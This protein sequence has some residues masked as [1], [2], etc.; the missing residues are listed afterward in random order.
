MRRAVLPLAAAAA[1]LLATAGAAS[2]ALTPVPATE[3]LRT[4]RISDLTGATSPSGEVTLLFADQNNGPTVRAVTRSATGAFGP[5][6]NLSFTPNGEGPKAAYLPDGSLFA[7][8]SHATSSAAGAFAS[9]PAGGFFEPPRALPTGE[10]FAE[11]AT[12]PAGQVVAVWKG[13]QTPGGLDFVTASQRFTNGAFISTSPVSTPVDDNFIQPQVALTP[14]GEVL[15]AWAAATSPTTSAIDARIGSLGTFAPTFPSP[16]QAIVPAATGSMR[17]DEVLAGPSGEGV[18]LMSVPAGATR[19][20]LLSRRAPGGAFGAPEPI[21]AQGGGARADYDGAGDLAIAWN[22][23]IATDTT[24]VRAAILPAGGTL[25]APVD[26]SAPG[27][28]TQILAVDHD[29][30]GNVVVAWRRGVDATSS[31]LEATRLRP[32][33]S[34]DPVITLL[35]PTSGAGSAAA[36]VTPAGDVVAAQ[37]EEV[38]AAV[39][40]LRVGGADSGAP[41]AFTSTT[42]PAAGVVGTPVAMSAAATDFSGIAAIDWDFGDGATAQGGDV[43]HT[44][45]TP[46]EKTVTIR[47]TDGGGNVQTA[48]RTVTVVAPAVAGATA[49]GGVTPTTQARDTRP[50]ALRLTG[51]RRLTAT[52]FR[53]GV[54]VTVRADEPSTVTAEL[55]AVA[56]GA[57]LAAARSPNLV[58]AR[59]VLKDVTGAR[60]VRLR[61]A[62]RLLGRT[63]RLTATV[64]ITAQD[65]SGNSRTSTRRVRVRPG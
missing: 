52:A 59:R 20:A 38:S 25:G 2:A 41:P 61:P 35:G 28:F 39:T 6:A 62:A 30:A 21:T 43:S 53:K 34:P 50:P 45:A 58:L 17:V 8:W 10:R 18:I 16:V 55:L 26:L 49:G 37:G 1:A 63:T 13:F 51:P 15:V 65:A 54:A 24:R 31:V 33:G 29:A 5:I 19:A 42:L 22:E 46:G 36:T 57:K 47:A 64:R 9:R 32:G 27:T 3:V 48:T 23:V 60:T 12:N 4:D 56:T 7:L 44:Y 14:S 11:L 40:L